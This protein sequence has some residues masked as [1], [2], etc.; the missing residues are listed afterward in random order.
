MPVLRPDD[1]W[2][3]T[4]PDGSTLD[5]TDDVQEYR[6]RYG[7]ELRN[8]PAG[9]RLTP[10]KGRLRVWDPDRRYDPTFHSAA[11]TTTAQLPITFTAGGT[12]L[13]SG[14]AAVGEN[15]ELQIGTPITFAL[16]DTNQ[17]ALTTRQSYQELGAQDSAELW[18][19]ALTA[20]GVPFTA[21]R[22]DADELGPVILTNSNPLKFAAE[23]ASYIGGWV[24]ASAS[25]DLGG[26]SWNTARSLAAPDAPIRALSTS[27]VRRRAEWVRTRGLLTA[28]TLSTASTATLRSSIVE[29]AVGDSVELEYTHLAPFA[30][31]VNWATPTVAGGATVTEVDSEPLTQIIRVSARSAGTYIVNFRGSVVSIAVSEIQRPIR[32]DAETQFAESRWEPPSWWTRDTFATGTSWLIGAGSTPPLSMSLYLSRWA[33][34]TAEQT[35][36]SS[37]VPGAV[38]T[39]E[40]PEARKLLVLGVEYQQRSRSAP[41]VL[42]H[43]VAI[44]ESAAGITRWDAA[45]WNNDQWE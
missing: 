2:A 22:I 28:L 33:R 43:G 18:D 20:F 42:V 37:L 24:Y 35:A 26:I 13:W 40:V 3:I 15:V 16:T 14:L 5:I 9:P 6:V 29:L 36:V 31:T 39:V 44:E 25:G 27:V 30:V 12:V 45:E 41:T 8:D 10:A 1:Q 32:T 23:Y 21:P 17:A 11:L 4:L 19:A 34:S 38:V 7:A